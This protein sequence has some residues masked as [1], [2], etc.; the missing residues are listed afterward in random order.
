[1]KFKKRIRTLLNFF[2]Q[3]FILNN[4]EVSFKL[5]DIDEKN[6]FVNSLKAQVH[7]KN[8]VFEEKLEE[9]FEKNPYFIGFDAKDTNILFNAIYT[10]K[11][12]QKYRK[13]IQL[14]V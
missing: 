11:Y 2:K 8:A 12:K 14:Y 3:L 6:G 10:L 13:Q 7:G 1:M 5:I 4:D 9:V